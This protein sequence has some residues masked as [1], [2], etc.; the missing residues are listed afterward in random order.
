M[1]DTVQDLIR[2]AAK[3]HGISPNL[4]L[5]VAEQESGFNPT[6]TGPVIADGPAKGQRAVGTF[7]IIPDTGTMLGIDIHDPRQNIDGGVRYLRMLMDQHKGDLD[8]VLRSYG[9]VVTDTEYVPSVR[10]RIKKW[11]SVPDLTS[12]AAQPVLGATP[13]M[14]APAAAAPPQ[15]PPGATR[16]MLPQS[17]PTTTTETP[18]E[19]PAERESRLTRE[20]VGGALGGA[21]AG[22]ARTIYGGGDLLRRAVGAERIIDQPDVQAAM[23][24]PAGTPG[25]AGMLAEQTAEF[26]LGGG[27]VTKGAQYLRSLLRAGV[28][29]T[30][31]RQAAALAEAG[32]QALVGGT[33][34]AAHGDDPRS[35]AIISAAAPVASEMITS[36]APAIKQAA[37]TRMARYMERGTRGY[38]TTEQERTLAQAAADFIELPLQRTWRQ[39]AK[40]VAGRRATAGQSLEAGLDSAFGDTPVPWAPVIDALDDYILSM[41]RLRPVK[42]GY[43]FKALDEDAVAAATTLKDYMVDHLEGF[44]P[45]VT[46]RDLHDIKRVWQKG[47]F[48]RAAKEAA[49]PYPSK[50]ELLTTAQKEALDRG[51]AAIIRV[52]RND[53]PEIA[54][55]DAAVS[56]AARLD[57]LVKR[58][59]AKSRTGALAQPTTKYAIGAAGGATGLAI[60]GT[61]GHPFVG[62][63]IGYGTARLL[64]KAIESPKWRLQPMVLRRRIAN[65]LASGDADLARK[66]LT[67]LALEATADQDNLLNH[68]NRN[69]SN[70]A[71]AS[72]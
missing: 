43:Q 20:T 32:G 57:Q 33:L 44:G 13:L 18:F 23:T 65:A 38:I 68:Q 58:L 49:Q 17:T 55:L 10:A 40:M 64:L 53:A 5:A 46:A 48:G 30:R 56:H 39:T 28:S 7:Q 51:Q 50:R 12:P 8:A 34:A 9:G 70:S 59:A 52:L 24:P 61:I 41:Q 16:G 47:I 14:P 3:K 72:R 63:H 66:I 69:L 36:M 54:Q 4:P 15:L 31:A 22:L 67:P 35:A 42:G 27:A 62:A 60:G 45:T 71:S 11:S 21:R 29:P 25:Q 6:L 37:I 19:T 1:P 26:A 2:A